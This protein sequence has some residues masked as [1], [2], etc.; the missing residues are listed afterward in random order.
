MK[1]LIP[2]AALMLLVS[3]GSGNSENNQ[4][5][6]NYKLSEVSEACSGS[7]SPELQVEQSG[8]SVSLSSSGTAGSAGSVDG[9][10]SG[11]AEAGVAVNTSK[12]ASTGDAPVL[13][14]PAS[15][16]A[17]GSVD[18]DGGFVATGDDVECSGQLDASGAA[19]KTIE[20]KVV[21]S[22]CTLTYELVGSAPASSM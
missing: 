5:G 17:S 4:V 11:T 14:E 7:F 9:S 18:S 16:D 12:N 8:G 3:C 15:V 21:G 19:P 20:C 13:A 10:S 2:L 6:G 22:N 1:K